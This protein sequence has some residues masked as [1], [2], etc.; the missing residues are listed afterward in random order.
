[1]KL[2]TALGYRSLDEMLNSM[3]YAEYRD[4]LAF[5]REEGYPQDR[6]DLRVAKLAAIIQQSAGKVLKAGVKFGDLV[7][8]F[9]PRSWSDPPPVKPIDDDKRERLKE[10]A[11]ELH[12]ALEAKRHGIQDRS[13]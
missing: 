7:D 6:D 13:R 12:E 9:L 11:K 5:F 3:S 4:W 1:M 8:D 2:C 10:Q